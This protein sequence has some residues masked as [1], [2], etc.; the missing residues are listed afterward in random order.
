MVNPEKYLQVTMTLVRAKG[1]VTR[2]FLVDFFAKKYSLPKKDAS[3]AVKSVVRKLRRRGIITLRGPGV[4][5][6]NVP[7]AAPAAT[8]A[9]AEPEL[10]EPQTIAVTLESPD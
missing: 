4:Y 2:R 1:C 7:A 5:C 9:P 6:W 10:P 3:D 8:P